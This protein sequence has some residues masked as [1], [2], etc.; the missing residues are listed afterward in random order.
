MP[1]S[2]GTLR[3]RLRDSLDQ[4]VAIHQVGVD[5]L[6]AR[7]SHHDG[8]IIVVRPNRNRGAKKTSSSIVCVQPVVVH[9]RDA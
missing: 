7:L 3:A 6:D 4:P 9:G 1:T 5:A 8:R 2:D